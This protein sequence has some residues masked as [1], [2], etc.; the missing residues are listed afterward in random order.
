MLDRALKLHKVAVSRSLPEIK[1]SGLKLIEQVVKR[2][3]EI[4]ETNEKRECLD[5]LERS[6]RLGAESERM[7]IIGSFTD[8][9]QWILQGETLI[10][11]LQVIE[12][13]A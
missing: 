11:G 3:T 1:K 7:A 9:L 12:A 4:A 13:L 10:F 2:R 8:I 5:F 6:V